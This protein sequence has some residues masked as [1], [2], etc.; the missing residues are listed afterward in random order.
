MEWGRL[1]EDSVDYVVSVFYSAAEVVCERNRKVFEL[2]GEA[3]IRGISASASIL[4]LY[5]C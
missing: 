2:L 5:A 1:T 3:L 4:V